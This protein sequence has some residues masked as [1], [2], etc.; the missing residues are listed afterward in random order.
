MGNE[1][2]LHYTMLQR[3]VACQKFPEVVFAMNGFFS[4]F[5]VGSADTSTF[6]G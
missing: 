6:C 4:V 2:E 3:E 1:N 5:S